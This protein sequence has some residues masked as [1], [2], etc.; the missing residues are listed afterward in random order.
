MDK[1]KERKAFGFDVFGKFPIPK[2][3][4]DKAFLREWEQA[5]GD[6]INID[7]LKR[8]LKNISIRLVH[9]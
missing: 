5:A 3:K 8:Y 9:F 4:N 2:F 7:D 1:N 6:G